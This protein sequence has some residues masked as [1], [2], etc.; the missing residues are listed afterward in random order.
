MLLWIIISIVF[1]LFVVSEVFYL[2]YLKEQYNQKREKLLNQ[3]NSLVKKEDHFKKEVADLETSLAERFLFYDIARK[4]SPLLS[5]KELFDVF[6]EE[7]RYLGQIEDIKFSDSAKSGDYLKFELGKD[8][9]QFL[10]LKTKSKAV[11]GYI[12]Y[13]AKLL[14]LCLERIKLYDQLQE[15]SIP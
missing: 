1:L 3:Y 14:E 5:K 15:L 9:H 2:N 12:P 4:I 7:I 8:S 10:Q 11:I 13:F 6:G